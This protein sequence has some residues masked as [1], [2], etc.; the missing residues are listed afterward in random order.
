MSSSIPGAASS[1]KLLSAGPILITFRDVREDQLVNTPKNG[2]IHV[3][4]KVVVFGLAVLL[5]SSIAVC[6]GQSSKKNEKP[7]PGTELK[8]GTKDIGKGSVE[9]GKALGKGTAD[10][11]KKTVKGDLGGAGKSLGKGAGQFGKDVG[12][13]TGSGVKKIGKGI[14]GATKKAGQAVTGG[15]DKKD[16]GKKSESKSSR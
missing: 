5:F 2:G 16:N 1:V 11:G 12:K 8:E 4:N 14:R 13:G 15:G 6:L 3:R 7:S 10:F 9:G